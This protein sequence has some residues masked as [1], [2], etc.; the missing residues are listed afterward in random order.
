MTS[1]PLD[2]IDNFVAS[3]ARALTRRRFMRNSGGV[4]LGAALATS[5]GP[6]TWMSR[7]SHYPYPQNHVCGPSP[8]C[9]HQTRCE[10]YRCHQTNRTSYRPY[11]GSR[12]SGTA[13]VENCWT[14]C[15]HGDLFYCC[16]CCVDDYPGANVYG[17]HPGFCSGCPSSQT[18][19]RC[20]CHQRVRSC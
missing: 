18:W 14:I 6:R 8:Y 12:C 16:D 13:G 2:R 5:L 20:I 7:A 17:N 3:S 15:F 19:Y 9:N 10:G 4:A 11:G 1:P